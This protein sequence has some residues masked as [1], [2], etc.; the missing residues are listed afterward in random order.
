M[1]ENTGKDDENK[2]D[3]RSDWD[4]VFKINADCFRREKSYWTQRV[5]LCCKNKTKRKVKTH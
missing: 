1:D 5:V 2:E 3:S 4:T